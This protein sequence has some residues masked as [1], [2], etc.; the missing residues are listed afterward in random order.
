MDFK[1]LLPHAIAVGILLAVA[2]LFYAPNAFSGKVLPQGD[3]DKARGMQTEVMQYLK[4]GEASPLW[5][6]SAFG[7]M[8]AF[9]IYVRGKEAV[10]RAVTRTAFL[11]QDISA[12]WAQTFT[13]MFMV[14]LLLTVMRVDWRVSIFG[15]LSYGI[16]TYNVDILEAGHS[17]KMMALALAPGMLAGALLISWQRYLL[18]GGLLALITASQLYVNHVQITF[19]TLLLIGIYFLVDLVAAI[20][21]RTYISWLKSAAVVGVALLIGLSANLAKLWPTY[22]YSKETIRGKSELAAKAEKGDGLDKS[23][24]F[25]WSYGV[26]ESLTLLVPHYAGGGAGETVANTKLFKAVTRQMP[27]DMTRRDMERQIAPLFYNGKQPFVGTAI[28]FGAIVCFLALLGAFLVRGNEKWWLLISGLF[29]VSLAWGSNF[30]LN[31]IW[32]NVLPLFNK[33]RAVSMALGA[34]QLCF[35]LLAA[36]GLQKLMDGDV[37]VAAKKQA[38]WIAAGGTALLCL[39][40]IATAGGSGPNDQMLAQNPELMRLLAQDRVSLARNDAFRSLGFIALA[41][42]LLLVYLQGRLKAAYTVAAIAALALLDHWMV[43]TRTLNPDK[44]EDRKTSTAAPQPED[45]DKEI[46]KDT[47]LHYR[48]LDLARGGI[49]GNATTS[50]FHKSISGYHAAKLQRFQEV[51]ERYLEGNQEPSFMRVLGMMNTKYI[52]TPQKQV[53][54]NPAACGHAWLVKHYTIVPNGDAELDA[55]ATLNP[56]DSAVVQQS[57]AAALQGLDLSGADTAAQIKMTEYHPDKM[58]YKY[59]SA[60]EQLAIFPEQYYPADK[61]WNCYINGQPVKGYVKANYMLRG[62]RLPAGQDLTVEMRFEPRS[63]YTGSTV[64]QA[65]TI[66]ALLAFLGG[67]FWLFRYF[68]PTDPNQL[69]E[70]VRAAAAVPERKPAATPGTK[71]PVK[72]KKKG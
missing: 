5:T 64:A 54:P 3:N 28:Y 18:G 31:D 23:Y 11:G 57:F 49:T 50:Y 13:A 48:V 56:L 10:L 58:T 7:G 32:Y 19:Y 21:H 63:F 72:P 20:R 43:C 46:L 22:E 1:R 55:L 34:G 59:T 8:P 62:L 53:V 51:T 4:K 68:Q 16:T 14:Y 67:L 30:F 6:N 33:F 15:A 66:V 24:L 44:Y 9:Q 12:M 41:I 27:P 60:T 71:A 2:A 47:D 69:S 65:A 42:V 17:T 25:G 39:I 29:M 61:G 52:V 40:A 70:I 35:A 45:Y 36:L 38:L 37:A 26:G